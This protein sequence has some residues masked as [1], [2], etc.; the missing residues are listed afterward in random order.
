MDDADDGNHAADLIGKL[1]EAQKTFAFA[2][3][4]NGQSRFGSLL[5]DFL[6]IIRKKGY[7]FA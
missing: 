3:G 4:L 5:F 6:N 7:R 2:F 1:G